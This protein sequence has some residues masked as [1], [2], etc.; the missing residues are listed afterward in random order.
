M[1]TDDLAGA[2]WLPGDGTANPTDLTAALA[3]GA[4]NRGVTIRERIRVTGI[5]TA[6]GAVTGVRTDQGDV[7]AEIVVNC[8]G[9]WAK[10]VGAMVGVTV[11][12]HSAEHFYVVTEQIDGVAPRP[13]RS[14]ATRTATPTS[15]R[16]SAAWWS[17]ASSRTPSRGS[18][19]T[20]CPT[21][22]SSSCSTRTGTTSR[23]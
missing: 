8:A 10:A 7:E 14:C 11:P 22:S 21:R 6:G 13:A 19:P 1:E 20:S 2:I 17:A 3:R 5:H 18:P 4:R 15:R 9:Q 23:S 16:R 12:L